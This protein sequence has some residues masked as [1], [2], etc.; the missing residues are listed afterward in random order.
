MEGGGETGR[1]LQIAYFTWG[2][3]G[4]FDINEVWVQRNGISQAQERWGQ[5]RVGAMLVRSSH[6]I[7]G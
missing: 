3:C 2:S 5:V 7:L 1:G 6:V 4:Q